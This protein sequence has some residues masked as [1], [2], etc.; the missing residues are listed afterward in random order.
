[1]LYKINGLKNSQENYQNSPAIPAQAFT[2]KFCKV[3][4]N[5][6]Y[7]EHLRGTASGVWQLGIQEVN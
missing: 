5:T 3:F 4:K 7:T 6:S 1:M 2:C